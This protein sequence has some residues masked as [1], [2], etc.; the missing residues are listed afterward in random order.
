MLVRKRRGCL[1]RTAILLIGVTFALGLAHFTVGQVTAIQPPS[2]SVPREE[3]VVVS[4]DLA[5][6]GWSYF[7]RRNPLLEFGLRG[8]PEELGWSHARLAQ[9]EMAY[10]EGVLWGEFQSH[11]PTLLA[12]TLL[13]DLAQIRYRHVDQGVMADRRREL[14]AQASGFASDPF[15]SI[16]PTYQ[17]LVFLNSLYDIAL[18]FEHSPLVGCTSLVMDGVTE[19]GPTTL[20]ARAFDFEIDVFDERKAVFLVQ[21]T[22]SIPFASVAWPGMVGVVSGMNAEGVALVVH[23]ARAGDTHSVGE[24]VLHSLR[25][26]LSTARTTKDALRELAASDPMVSHLVILTDAEG[27]S[28]VVERVPGQP[29]HVRKLPLRAAVANH[30]E[31]PWAGHP[32]NQTVLKA[33]TTVPRRERGDELMAALHSPATVAD[34]VR[35]L[36]DRRGAGNTELPLGDRRAIDAL[37]ATHGVVMDTRHRVL[38]VSESPHLLGRF[39]AFD[40]RVMLRP[41]YQPQS[42][43]ELKSLPADPFLTSGEYEKWRT[44]VGRSRP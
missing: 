44:A 31:G 19:E 25:R 1:L 3:P 18:S 40:L 7:L 41:D 39:V 27:D 21:E 16:F 37:I 24:P 36:R 4:R 43:V 33:T 30:L 28:V 9:E 8:S 38:W 12:R 15:S 26:V 10:D 2:V 34:A 11:V 35:M 6:L 13:L 22:G 20:L 32:K 29:Q 5:V 23:G 17:R 14:A 42:S